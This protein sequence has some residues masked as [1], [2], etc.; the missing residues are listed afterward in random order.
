MALPVCGWPERE[1]E[2]ARR[3]S[4]PAPTE[5]EP[6]GSEIRAEEPERV[7]EPEDDP[8]ELVLEPLR[9]DADPDRVADDEG[10]REPAGACARGGSTTRGSGAR[11]SGA[12]EPEPPEP[13]PPEEPEDPDPAGVRGIAWANETAGTASANARAATTSERGFLSIS[14][15]SFNGSQTRQGGSSC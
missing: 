9:D 6:E 10:V 13:E 3:F 8:P 1:R 15:H 2:T 12:L 11:D 4:A 7:E 14:M 5:A